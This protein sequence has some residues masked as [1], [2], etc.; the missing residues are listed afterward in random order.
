MIGNIIHKL[1]RDNKLSQDKLAKIIGC[2]QALISWWENN[3]VS[4]KSEYLI[5]LN[6]IFNGKLFE[7]LNTGVKLSHD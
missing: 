5:K 4:P 3:S 7:E 1:R 2:S 6:K